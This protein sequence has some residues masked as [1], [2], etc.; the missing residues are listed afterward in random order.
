MRL[1]SE[2]LFSP[3]QSDALSLASFQDICD[4]WSEP[5]QESLSSLSPP[6]S[7][8]SLRG[9]QLL[10]WDSYCSE[11]MS[12]AIND[13]PESPSDNLNQTGSSTSAPAQAAQAWSSYVGYA[14]Q[15]T[16][17]VA[18]MPVAF[19]PESTPSWTSYPQLI[20]DTYDGWPN[21]GPGLLP[22]SSQQVPVVGASAYA[23][24]VLFDTHYRK[25][26]A[27]DSGARKMSGTS[28]F[29]MASHPGRTAEEAAIVEPSALSYASTT[30][31]YKP[32]TLCI[33][34]ESFSA[35]PNVEFTGPF[36][37]ATA[38]V[39]PPVPTLT[40]EHGDLEAFG[41]PTYSHIASANPYGQTQGFY[42]FPVVVNSH[43]ARHEVDPTRQHCWPALRPAAERRSTQP[44][45]LSPSQSTAAPIG[46][47]LPEKEGRFRTHPHYAT[48]PKADGH[49]YCPFNDCTHKPTKLKCNYD[50]YIDSHIKP[51]RCR[52]THCSEQQFSSTACLLRHEREAHG[53]H[54]HGERPNLCHY[55]DCD[56]A[57]PGHGFPRHYNLMDHMR[58]VHG[59]N[60]VDEVASPATS[61]R[62]A[63]RV[64]KSRKRKGNSVAAETL[65]KSSTSRS[66]QRRLNS[67]GD[68][69]R[70]Q[71]LA[72]AV[73]R[74]SLG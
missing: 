33:K 1:F 5:A 9:S 70:T 46:K 19:V 49:Y 16:T 20:S 29:S 69:A 64:S 51:F 50:K 25:S 44:Q 39:T 74:R 45:P 47:S 24:S 58:R 31:G 26:S 63:G 32:E 68:M 8:E 43:Q 59:H 27:R 56:R 6:D 12:W 11:D 4:L 17:A 23:D 67:R 30:L 28:S 62:D 57:Q 61:V 40:A 73:S 38:V 10:D 18:P 21:P 34:P 15:S 36:W 54:G 65:R 52:N 41:P 3:T 60:A 2:F 42:E 71:V 55:P 13:L 37:G 14:T 7:P 66:E 72:E 53:L 35:G 48:K 22:G